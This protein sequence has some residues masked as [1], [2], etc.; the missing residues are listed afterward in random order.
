MP[1][2]LVEQ[3]SSE[4]LQRTLDCRHGMETAS[5][6]R[7][8]SETDVWVVGFGRAI[9]EASEKYLRAHMHELIGLAKTEQTK[10]AAE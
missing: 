4:Y 10:D 7:E 2:D 6:E 8:M 5:A 9:M 1:A 3:R